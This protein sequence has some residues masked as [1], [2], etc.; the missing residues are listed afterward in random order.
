MFCRWCLYDLSHTK[1]PRC[2]E[3]GGGFKLGEP[4]S[5][6]PTS[7]RWNW[8]T[9]HLGLYLAGLG[10]LARRNRR[11]FCRECYADL[12]HAIDDKC[13]LCRTWFNPRDPDTYRRSNHALMRVYDR[14]RHICIWRGVLISLITL[15]IGLEAIVTQSTLLPGGIRGGARLLP[16][17]GWAAIAM[18]IAWLGVALMLHSRY[19]WHRVEPFW[20]Y[21]DL[22]LI[23]GLI[24]MLGGWGYALYLVIVP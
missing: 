10:D 13:P 7:S 4:R 20:R 21:A 24:I 15:I 19:F 9:Y 3:C 18:G 14:F 2:P 8:V 23:A 11:M 17:S 6:L 16:L 5:M 1:D 12:L 22:G